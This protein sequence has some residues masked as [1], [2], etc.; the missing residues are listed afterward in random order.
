M[1]VL[2]IEFGQ[3]TWLVDIALPRGSL[4]LPE[5]IPDL[6]DRYGF[7][8]FPKITEILE[9]APSIVFQHGKFENSVIRKFSVFNDG[10][11]AESQ[12]GNDHAVLFLENFMHWAE[13]QL[14]VSI[15]EISE[16]KIYY[17]SQMVIQLDVDLSSKL[18]FISF[19]SDSI[20]KYAS[21]YGLSYQGYEAS[22]IS[23]SP[24]QSDVKGYQ[25][26]PFRIERRVGQP[27]RKNIYYST[28]PLKTS[29]HK[30]LLEQIERT[31]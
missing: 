15:L 11:T 7:V 31:I 30:E 27:F 13:N 23:L 6:T 12:A 10:F 1:K 28:A 19:V 14:E 18:E 9:P 5:V 8:A 16:P 22:G 25:Y 26:S 21:D 29:D 20:G 2:S 3:A 17:D 24:D 4:Y